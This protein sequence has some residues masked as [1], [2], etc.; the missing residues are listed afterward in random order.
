V[1][2]LNTSS[3]PVATA[4]APYTASLGAI[5]GV[6]PYS[7][8]VTGLPSGLSVTG[9]GSFRGSPQKD[10][11][12][13][14]AV[15]LNDSGGNSATGTLTLTVNPAP[16][17]LLSGSLPGGTLNVAYSASLTASGGAP[18]YSF[19]LA[20]GV[21]PDGLR[22]SVGGIV[23]GL[24]AA[25]GTFSVVVRVTDSSAGSVTGNYT[26]PI[27][28]PPVVITN[29]S[30]LPSGMAGTDYPAQTLDATGGIGP[31]TF[32]VS[33]GSLPGGIKL[34]STGLI[35]GVPAA[36]GSFSFSV[37]AKDTTGLT[38]TTNLSIDIR[39]SA[40][41]LLLSSASLTFTIPAN[42]ASLPPDQSIQIQSTDVSVVLSW[43][44]AISGS[45]NWFTL[46]RAGGTTPAS[47]I[48]SLNN[49]ALSLSAAGSPYSV[50]IAVSCTSAPCAGKT[51]NVAVILSVL[52]PPPQLTVGAKSL[53]FSGLSAAPAPSS[54]G[55]TLTNSG[56]GSLGIG[57]VTCAA[58]WCKLSG[59]PAQLSA[60]AAQTLTVTADP[61][62]SG[63]GFFWSSVEIVSSG[64]KGLVPVTL[65]VAPKPSMIL[66]PAG[67]QTTLPAG[68]TLSVPDTSFNI[69]VSTAQGIPWTASVTGA[70][71]LKLAT[72]SGTAT[73]NSPS[74]VAF[75]FDSAALSQLSQGAYYNSIRVSSN[76]VI[77]SPQDF[78]VVVNVTSAAE[79]QKPNPSPAGLLFITSVSASPPAQEVGLYTS[80]NSQEQF[81]ASAFTQDGGSWLSA[82]PNAGVTSSSNIA[83]IR[84]SVDPSKL[85]PGVYRGQVDL[86]FA[87]NAVH[88]VN[89]TAVVTAIQI[90][91]APPAAEQSTEDSSV[92][93]AT[94]L[95]HAGCSPTQ[96]VPTQTGL[97]N[98]FSVPTA[99]P[100][101]L[102]IVLVND[103]GDLVNTGQIV[104]T[105]SNGDPPLALTLADPKSAR[106][107]A[108]W[109]P[110][111]PA[112]QVTISAQATA[113]GLAPST[114]KLATSVTPSNAPV[115]NK[116]AVLNIYNPVGGVPTAPGTLVVI[117]GSY[118][119]SQPA[120][121]TVI[122]V[123][124]ALGGTQVLIGGVAAPITA[125]SPSQVN[126]QVPFEL[127]AGQ[128]YQVVI[129]A[130][131][132]LTTP[133]GLQVADTSPGLSLLPSG[134]VNATHQS[135]SAI[136]ET[137]PAK[138]GELI[139]VYLAGMGLTS[140]TIDSGTAPSTS[141]S[142]LIQ[143]D[144]TV[145]GLPV[146]YLYAGLT[147][148]L[149][150]VYQINL[151]VPDNTPD[152]N[153]P[154]QL[155]QAGAPS[156]SGLLPVKK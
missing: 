156:N 146:T 132:A 20:G 121:N 73:G 115:L 11:N 91:A 134:F 136:T 109:T 112:A 31:Y 47:F 14:V 98:N 17:L 80:S 3:L 67:F 65:F 79:R 96:V 139:A 110:R 22:L 2:G 144:I 108:T 76:G 54:L 86:A 151:R 10:G 44:A 36:P 102:E 141:A 32:T 155:S 154:L 116:D 45:T 85:K 21:L 135:G 30:P 122:P 94:S 53:S 9:D 81:Q 6:P 16:P 49:S 123:P 153:Q 105:F 92:A 101:P 34:S 52:S 62:I 27:V 127:K 107:S 89:V 64:G 147:P 124:T 142:V 150:G 57:S 126:V 37:T 5:G 145:G 148:G 48:I 51:Q 82:T 111:K 71:W 87:G 59:I 38:G 7:F 63:A 41:D 120:V 46:N 24:P 84:V 133:D 106:Y 88:S 25:T 129:S 61:S 70:P 143:P 97:A 60:G 55:L 39:P 103:C 8:T 1:L 26:I 117:K 19:S 18:P 50:N 83:R 28:P 69:T 15:A 12:F 78:T 4:F 90:Q 35:S 43:T 93:P 95:P 56:G 104:S 125:V 23:S 29:N 113:A 74:T 40:P 42:S 119:A 66:A 99:W 33:S 114:I 13:T 130:N 140:L 131:G 128:P 138:P 58:V 137:S 118:L 100:T 72:T 77:N 152:G 149:V 68:G 75:F